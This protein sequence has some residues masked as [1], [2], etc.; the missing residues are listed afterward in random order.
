MRILLVTL[1]FSPDGV[2]TASLMTDL[3]LELERCGH[4]VTV[5]TTTP[6]YNHEPESRARQQLQRRWAGL[7]Y[8]S[9]LD[10]IE[11]QHVKVAQKGRR[12][13]SRAFDYLR[14][15]MIGTL[16]GLLRAGPF[17]VVLAPTPP[18]TIG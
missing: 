14:F 7:L 16:A 2:S 1:V 6:H 18:L 11:V 12:I 13:L 4:E 3:A 10:S 15:H 5:L 9:Q 8:T 17:D